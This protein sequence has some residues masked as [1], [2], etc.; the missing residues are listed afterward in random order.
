MPLCSL[1]GA[2]AS[3]MYCSCTMSATYLCDS[4]FI[5]HRNKSPSLVHCTATVEVSNF[6][7]YLQRCQEFAQGKE[8]LLGNIARIDK[9][10]TELANTVEA[11]II[12]IQQ[13][14]DEF[15]KQLQ[16]LKGAMERE[17]KESLEETEA[18][19]VQDTVELKGK[20]SAALRSYVPNSLASFTYQI[21]CTQVYASLQSLIQ[22]QFSPPTQVPSV[23]HAMMPVQEEATEIFWVTEQSLRWFDART[24]QLHLPV[25]LLAPILVDENSR[26][27]VV[28][29]SSV[30]LC[31]GGK[32]SKPLNTA[33]MLSK[34]GEVGTLPD[35]LYGHESPG[36]ITWKGRVL[37]FGS[38]RGPGRRQ[39]EA[40]VLTG[41]NWEALPEMHKKRSEFAPAIWQDSVYLCG[42]ARNRSVERFDG[43]SLQLLEFRFPEGIQCMAC[44]NGNTLLVLSVNYMIVI[45]K[46]RS[47]S[48]PDYVLKPRRGAGAQSF[49]PPVIW[50]QVI[51]SFDEDGDVCKYSAESGASLD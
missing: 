17:I 47:G 42:G 50:N 9:C 10:C 27:A 29:P 33:Y 16:A 49:T 38:S 8:E 19:L 48:D 4:C 21:D 25:Q 36:V 13:Y 40:L 51:Y 32:T 30:V 35:L 6:S 31:G 43:V 24:S 18:S 22:M 11:L 46:A 44:A 39:C 7:R 41:E 1:C 34:T 15:L 45:S 14:K 28:D 26:W 2:A 23:H 37:V 20:Y 12:Q 5:P 3:T